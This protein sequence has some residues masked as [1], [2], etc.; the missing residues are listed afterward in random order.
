MAP[1]FDHLTKET[2]ELLRLPNDQRIKEIRAER[3]V[4][5]PRAKAALA[6]MT[7]LATHPRT[8]RMP[9]LA[10]YGD[11]G[12]GKTMLMQKF[13]E[14]HP[15]LLD[16]CRGLERQQVLPIQ[17]AGKPGERQLFAQILHALGVHHGMR[18]SAVD[19]QFAVLRMLKAV[20]L[21]VLV[22][23]EVHNI[24]AGSARDQRIVLNTLR[25]LSNE[26]QISLVCF[27]VAD[28]REAING[29]V[30]LARRFDELV[31][32][33]WSS[34]PAFEELIISILRNM[35]L[36]EPSILT[37]MTLRRILQITDGLTARIFRLMNAL[38]I[39]AIETG[40][41]RITDAAVEQWSP[42]FS[43]DAAFA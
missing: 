28:A 40:V 41:E 11:S 8:T 21:Q 43:A 6:A 7:E 25:Y 13:C 39:A 9:S 17:M 20:D 2:A 27:G 19:M 23:D 30:Q 22:I 3:W 4:H 37:A 16:P 42:I 26:L 35:P 5:H 29:D 33:R 10:I 15:P 38:A 36:R 34:N 12:M 24:L 1:Q 14:T 18:A 31:L 32:T